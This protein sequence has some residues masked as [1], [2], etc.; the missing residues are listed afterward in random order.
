VVK[1]WLHFYTMLNQRF[2]SDGFLVIRYQ[3]AQAEK[4]KYKSVEGVYVKI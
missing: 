1:S 3:E 4:G 2:A